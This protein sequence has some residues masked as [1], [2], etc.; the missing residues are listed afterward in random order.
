[1]KIMLFRFTIPLT[2]CLLTLVLGASAEL[3]WNETHNGTT[4]FNIPVGEGSSQPV[5]S[6]QDENNR[7][8]NTDFV[9]SLNYDLN[10]LLAVNLT[11][12]S[13]PNTSTETAQNPDR[14]VT[15]CEKKE[16]KAGA[17]MIENL[18]LIPSNNVIYP[19]AVLQQDHTLAEG[20]PTVYPVLRAPIKIYVKLPGLGDRALVNI[21]NP[22]GSNVNKEIDKALDYWFNYQQ[23]EGYSTPVLAAS[24]ARQA[25]TKEQI[26][27]DLGFGAQWVKSSAT[28]NLKVGSSDEK[29]FFYKTFKQIYYTVFVDDPLDAG[30]V[31]ADSIFMGDV[32]PKS[33]AEEHPPGFISSVDYGRIII[34]QVESSAKENQV[35]AM[36]NAKLS[37]GVAD[38][39]IKT[40][41]TYDRIANESSFQC[42]VMGGGAS[43]APILIGGDIELIRDA[44]SGGINLSRSNMPYPISYTV[45][46]L[47]TREI[48]QIKTTTD[49][50]ETTC[51]TLQKHVITLTNKGAYTAKFSVTWDTPKGSDETHSNLLTV[52][53]EYSVS[54]PADATNVKVKGTIYTGVAWEWRRYE[55][56]KYDKIDKDISV[57]IGGTTFDSY[58]KDNY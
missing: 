15:V 23:V 48:S 29:A 12:N 57:W 45:K 18:L 49:Y 33:W 5:Q 6:I 13:L 34:V 25:Y 20:L 2:I 39:K 14:S 56:K 43:S 53:K 50:I 35:N 40:N 26:G 22:S 46:D 7:L 27:I 47:K 31:F 36:L 1:M 38:F 42:F 17:D 11:P 16:R 41:S 19:G 28:A 37:K 44:I 52:N 3:T 4:I 32:R 58:I 54:V 55:T 21:E 8:K 24:T 30:S 10:E 9:N 51:N